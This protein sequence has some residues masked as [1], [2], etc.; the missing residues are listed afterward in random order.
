[1]IELGGKDI[2]VLHL[3]RDTFNAANGQRAQQCQLHERRY[4]M[5][6]RGEPERRAEAKN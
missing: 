5:I 4:D 6:A 3:E 1:M 2:V